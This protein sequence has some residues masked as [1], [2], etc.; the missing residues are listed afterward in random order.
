MATDDDYD[1][2]GVRRDLTDINL[3]VRPPTRAPLHP[4]QPNC[5]NT[6]MRPSSSDTLLRDSGCVAGLLL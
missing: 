3:I 2:A 6:R 4:P 1:C 5:V